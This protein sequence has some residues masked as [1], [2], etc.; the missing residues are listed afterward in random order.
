MCHLGLGQ[1]HRATAGQLWVSERPLWTQCRRE[2]K[3]CA[4]G[5]G[6]AVVRVRSNKKIM[7]LGEKLLN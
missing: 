1:S 7:V 4:G 2:R 3:G 6:L 5:W